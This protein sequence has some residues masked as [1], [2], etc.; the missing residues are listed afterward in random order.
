MM[1]KMKRFLSVLLSTLMLISLT[2]CVSESQVNEYLSQIEDLNHEV[3]R[4]QTD[5]TNLS[6]K[7]DDLNEVIVSLKNTNS[8]LQDE[9][10]SL[11]DKL[12]AN[13]YSDPAYSQSSNQSSNQLSTSQTVY[14][15]N[16]GS[17]YHK[18]GC[19]YLRQSCIAISL[20]NATSQGYTP[21]SKCY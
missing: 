9:V 6:E 12:N 17:K 10:S 8:D 7:V 16:T 2:S 20:S 4:L 5:K 13:T 18:S 14:V 15:T 21:C 1:I 19:Q 3:S 11:E